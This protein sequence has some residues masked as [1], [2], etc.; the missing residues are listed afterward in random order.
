MIV[1]REVAWADPL[2]KMLSFSSPRK[3]FQDPFWWFSTRALN[4]P[5]NPRTC[6]GPAKRAAPLTQ[7]PVGELLKLREDGES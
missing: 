4:Q 6:W 1:F 5:L 7:T 2:E 3:S